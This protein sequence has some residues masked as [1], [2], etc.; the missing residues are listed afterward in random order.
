M[1]VFS[2]ESAVPTHAVNMTMH[3]ITDSDTPE[4]KIFIFPNISYLL[5]L[6]P[7]METDKNGFA[8]RRCVYR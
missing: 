8:Q 5:L 2:A 6:S 4:A 3:A 1:G 7:M